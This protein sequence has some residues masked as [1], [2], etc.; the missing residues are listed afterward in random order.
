M[1]KGELYIDENYLLKAMEGLTGE[2]M[3][4]AK[5]NAMMLSMGILKRQTDKL[6][7]RETRL[8]QRKKKLPKKGKPGKS[9]TRWNKKYNTADVHIMSDFMMKWFEVGTRER[10]THVRRFLVV[11]GRGD[12]VRVTQKTSRSK[13]T[14]SIKAKRL[15]MQARNQ[16][17]S[18]ILE[19]FDRKLLRAIEKVWKKRKK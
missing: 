5:K 10:Y 9:K 12:R 13:P 15:F 4:K 11:D 6:Y 3:L 14:G 7:V 16:T 19:E 1:T 8:P 18:R 17:S 2:E